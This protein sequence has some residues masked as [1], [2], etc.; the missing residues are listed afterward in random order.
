MPELP[1]VE[2]MRRGIEH[3]VGC[4]ITA[5]DM[6]RGRHKSIAIVPEP[7]R[8]RRGVLGKRLEGTE[9]RGKRVVIRLDDQQ[10]IVFEPRMTGLVLVADP[11]NK[12]H[13]RMQIQLDGQQ[14]LWYWDRRGLGIVTLYDAQAYEQDLGPERLGPDALQVT[15]ELLAERLA[16]RKREIKVAL[17]DQHLVAGIG[18]LYASEILHVAGIHPATRCDHLSGR[19]WRV[20]AEAVVEVLQEAIFYE[21]STLSDGTYRNTLNKSGG[22]QNHHRVYDRK[23]QW[24]SKCAGHRVERMVQAQ[25]ST[26]FCPG[27]QRK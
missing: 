4:S 20:L 16:E 26:F 23:D 17:M 24:C 10:R 12:E 19:Q 13:L 14:S 5:V 21:G 1:E 8:F 27:C 2:T 15:P 3:L 11:P 18:N 9:R 7:S 25:R 6:P 22:Y